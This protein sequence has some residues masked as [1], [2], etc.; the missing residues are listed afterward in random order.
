MLHRNR[1]FLSST[2]ITR[3]K[4][5]TFWQLCCSGSIARLSMWALCN[6]LATISSLCFV[7]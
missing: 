4:A 3:I 7:S 6:M 2:L 1:G 5:Q